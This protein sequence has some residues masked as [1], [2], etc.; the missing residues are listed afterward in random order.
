M[1]FEGTNIGETVSTLRKAK[2]MSRTV[3]SKEAGISESHLKKIETGV[4][5]PGMDTYQKILETL[6]AEILIIGKEKTVKG[7]CAAKMQAILMNSTEEQA[8]FMTAVMECMA[9]NIGHVQ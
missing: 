3:L 4:R 5:Q 7:G 1:N 8:V 9:H 6:E 2:G